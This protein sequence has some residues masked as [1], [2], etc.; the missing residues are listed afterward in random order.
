MN[1]LQ[2]LEGIHFDS[3]EAIRGCGDRSPGPYSS[4]DNTLTVMLSSD[5][6]NGGNIL[7]GFNATYFFWGGA[8]ILYCNSKKKKK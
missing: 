1:V 3:P 5:G 6:G 7:I 2:I 4:N 8:G